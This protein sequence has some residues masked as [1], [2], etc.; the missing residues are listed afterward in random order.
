VQYNPAVWQEWYFIWHLKT[1]ATYSKVSHPARENWMVTGKYVHLRQNG[2]LDEE[3]T[4][5]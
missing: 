5:F 4:S 2:K 1:S 3:Y